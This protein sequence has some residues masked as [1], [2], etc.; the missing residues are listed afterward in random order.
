MLEQREEHCGAL[1]VKKGAV[2]RDFRFG[3]SGF[4]GSATNFDGKDAATAVSAVNAEEHNPATSSNTGLS[5]ILSSNGKQP[6]GF[7][8]RGRFP[9][10]IRH[11]LMC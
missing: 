4:L 7:E 11:W 1:A 2:R 3:D 10:A 9:L 6:C 5:E 8:V